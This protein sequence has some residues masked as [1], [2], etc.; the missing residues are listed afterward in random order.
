MLRRLTSNVVS[1]ASAAF[2][3]AVT[4]AVQAAT[5]DGPPLDQRAE[6]RAR[7]L[8]RM[9]THYSS[10]ERAH[11][12]LAPLAIEPVV[13][14]AGELVRGL[15]M[16]DVSWP[17]RY[18]PYLPELSER[19][20]RTRENSL[21][22][23]RLF[24]R[25]TPRPLVLIL[26]GYM[27][28]NFAFEQRVWPIT[29]FDSLGLDVGLFVLPFHG[30]RADPSRRGRPEFPGKDPRFAN[31]GFRQAM[32]DL[33]SALAWL[34]ERGHP[35][36]GL[37][38]MSLGGYT[39]ALVATLDSQIDF[40]VPIV[41]LASLAD[42]AFEQGALSPAPEL[43]AREQLL[44]DDIHR[45]VSPLRAPSLIG[46][47]RVLVIGARA[48]RITPVAH[49]RRVATHFGAPLHTWHGGHLLQ[50]GRGQAFGKVAELLAKLEII[51]PRQ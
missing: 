43:A 22:A 25:G 11:F 51:P 2:D 44:L 40:L 35:R 45:L 3:R 18:E 8:E 50:F 37:L 24:T 47:E 7:L 15:S 20:L 12:H 30:R 13:R 32:L 34:R 31:E 19:Y 29:W 1:L 17:S 42:F 49:A 10:L 46:P 5:D 39:A 27:T 14:N 33:R 28:G 4:L 23:L 41:P 48:D 9:A 26:H 6:E 21:G 36:I 38:G 16:L